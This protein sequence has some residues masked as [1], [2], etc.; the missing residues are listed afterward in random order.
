[1][2]TNLQTTVPA[3]YPQ[4]PIG[5]PFGAPESRAASPVPPPFTSARS[6]QALEARQA[7]Q[8]QWATLTLRQ[9]W[10]DE[11]WM[12]AHLHEAGIRVTDSR[13][14]ATTSRLR[15]KLGRAGITPSEAREAVGGTLAEYLRMNPGLPLW[16][17][18]ALI[19]E[20]CTRFT[21]TT[22]KS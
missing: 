21:P 3:T 12:R 6:R 14:P 17:A 15:L 10:A 5:K 8:A 18:L 20:A 4:A 9:Q 7:R 11:A 19:V 22:A 16:A 1:M 2:H 13:E